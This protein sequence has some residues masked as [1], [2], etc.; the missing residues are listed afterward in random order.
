MNIY[1]P[2]THTPFV[3]LETDNYIVREECENDLEELYRLY[4][5]LSDCP[6][7]ELLEGSRA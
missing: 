5:T 2:E 6:F 7:I 1:M 4:D 3:S